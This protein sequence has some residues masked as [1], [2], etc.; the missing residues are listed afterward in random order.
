MT[1]KQLYEARKAAKMDR[2]VAEEQAYEARKR[3]EAIVDDAIMT[4]LDGIKSFFEGHA[5][6]HI[7]S[8]MPGVGTNIRFF[9]DKPPQ[10]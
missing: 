1:P 10:P 6:L 9:K 7:S 2:K 4:M 8:H 3:R 5:T